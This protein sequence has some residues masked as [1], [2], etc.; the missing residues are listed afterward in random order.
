M[1]MDNALPHMLSRSA[2]ESAIKSIESD[3]KY[4]ESAIKKEDTNKKVSAVEIDRK[5]LKS[6]Y[7][8]KKRLLRII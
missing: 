2:L 5:L 8:E 6:L 7:D 3:I 1:A 4:L